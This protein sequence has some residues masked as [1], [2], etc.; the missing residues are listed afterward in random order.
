[1]STNGLDIRFLARNR[2]PLESPIL[3]GNESYPGQTIA[4][5]A[6]IGHYAAIQAGLTT[7]TMDP[8]ERHAEDSTPI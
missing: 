5:L 3:A 4:P 6:A 8:E 2:Y 1:M 7:G